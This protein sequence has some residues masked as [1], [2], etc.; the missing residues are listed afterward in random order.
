VAALEAVVNRIRFVNT[1]TSSTNDLGGFTT[2]NWLLNAA[3]A[4]LVD[5]V[6]AR[7][8]ERARKIKAPRGPGRNR[9]QGARLRATRCADS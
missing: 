8:I 9:G 1:T 4:E 2:I 5:P 3:P 7:A 6:R